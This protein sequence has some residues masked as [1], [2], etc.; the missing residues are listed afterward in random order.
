MRMFSEEGSLCMEI[1]T[2]LFSCIAT[3]STKVSYNFHISDFIYRRIVI[4]RAGLTSPGLSLK[5]MM[6]I[7]MNYCY[8]FVCVLIPLYFFC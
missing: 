2:A 5:E 7:V 4:W 3:V 8:E 1:K 6:I